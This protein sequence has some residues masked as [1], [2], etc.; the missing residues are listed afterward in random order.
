MRSLEL[1]IPPVALVLGAAFLMWLAAWALPSMRFA[2]PAGAALIIAIAVAIMGTLVI[3]AGVIEFRHARTTVNPMNPD[4]A[5][6]L[7]VKRVY[8]ST[9]NPMYLGFTMLLL[10]WA[11]FLSHPLSFL[12]VPCFI[13][14]MNRFQIVPEERALEGRF[15]SEFKV[16]RSRVRRWL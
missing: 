14:Y 3:A 10:G 9:R 13:A 5:S 16:Y 6:S 15:G 1:R 4:A 11:V 8:A 2:I 7:V 12:V